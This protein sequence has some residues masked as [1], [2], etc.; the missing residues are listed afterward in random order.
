MVLVRLIDR[1]TYNVLFMLCGQCDG[2]YMI[3]IKTLMK[4]TM[5]NNIIFRILISI[6]IY[7]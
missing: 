7:V 1:S 5:L 4:A 3:I 2:N 6:Y